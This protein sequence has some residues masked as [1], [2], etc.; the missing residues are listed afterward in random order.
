MLGYLSESDISPEH[1]IGNICILGVT[2]ILQS[3]CAGRRLTFSTGLGWAGLG[4]AGAGLGWSLQRCFVL[5]QLGRGEG[6]GHRGGTGVTR[7]T[8]GHKEGTAFRNND[9]DS[10]QYKP[11]SMDSLTPIL[12]EL[13]NR[14][15]MMILL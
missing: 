15:A 14:D 11:G 2:A 8:S 3:E 13:R 9:E 10:V 6:G 7:H 5:L 1:G 12:S 4:W